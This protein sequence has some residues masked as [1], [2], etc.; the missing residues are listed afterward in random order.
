MRSIDP[1][2]QQAIGRVVVGDQVTNLAGSDQR[3]AGGERL[4]DPDVVIDPVETQQVDVIKTE[5]DQ[6]CFRC[7]DDARRPAVGELGGPP[8]R[9][10]DHQLVAASPAANPGAEHHFR[11]TG[12]VVIRDGDEVPARIR[13][14]I[15]D[16]LGGG[17]VR[18]PAEGAAT[19]GDGV[20]MNVG[21][22]EPAARDAVD[23]DLAGRQPRGGGGGS[24][25]RGAA[26]EHGGGGDRGLGHI[27]SSARLTR[28][29]GP[30]ARRGV[31]KR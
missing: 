13:I 1:T 21:T 26:R 3:I 11:A 10:G 9:G 6:R 18:G 20:D 30:F 23:D 19:E 22:P 24:R 2:G 12:G 4:L 5:P 8:C 29:L 27:P 14:P 25:V 31:T 16:R 15:E 28:R 7:G 17:G